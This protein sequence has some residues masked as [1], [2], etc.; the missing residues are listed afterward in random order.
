MK[1]KLTMKL[2]I[3]EYLKSIDIASLLK[4]PN[5]QRQLLVLKG[6]T[7]PALYKAAEHV[8]KYYFWG[9]FIYV[10]KEIYKNNKVKRFIDENNVKAILINESNSLE[11]PLGH[12][13]KGVI[14]CIH[15]ILPKAYYP[16]EDFHKLTFEHKFQEIIKILVSLGAKEIEVECKKG[17]GRDFSAKLGGIIPVEG[18]KVEVGIS[19]GKISNE[20]QY[21]LYRATFAGNKSPVLPVGLAWYSH[22]PSW[23]QIVNSRLN[24]QLIDFSLTL[25]Y[26]YDYGIN[27]AIKAKLEEIGFELGVDFHKFEST[28]WNISGKF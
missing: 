6:E 16:L 20:K 11:F 9:G 12:P 28:V 1:G 18:T 27:S 5:E 17:W 7:K 2:K 3:D 19:G 21:S 24:Y 23:Q 13:K 10:G 15:P 14:Y 25:N 22:E 8:A 4:L 26:E